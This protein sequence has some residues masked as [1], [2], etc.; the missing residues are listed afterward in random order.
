METRKYLA[1]Y[2]DGHDYGSFEYTSEHRSGSKANKADALAAYHKMYGFR[3]IR[4]IH[5]E[6]DK[7][8]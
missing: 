3:E 7:C 8:Y 2:D 1:T 4:I 5:T 6:L